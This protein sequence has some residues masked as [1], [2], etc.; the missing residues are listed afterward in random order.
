MQPGIRPPRASRWLRGNSTV[1][2]GFGL[3]VVLALL[4]TACAPGAQ[5]SAGSAPAKP[6]SQPAPA[7]SGQQPA[8]APQAAA[9]QP[10]TVLK[11]GT[12]PIMELL[13]LFV[14]KDEGF[15]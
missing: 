3:L 7:A 8:A 4:V 12:L 11:V 15:F 1:S 6:P 14:G 13:P 9:Q 5:P 10:P 2:S